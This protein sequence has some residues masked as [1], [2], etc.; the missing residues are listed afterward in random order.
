MRSNIKNNLKIEMLDD[1]QIVNQYEKEELAV[2]PA[3]YHKNG[4][5]SL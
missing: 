4:T 5:G 3:K 1:E 2:T